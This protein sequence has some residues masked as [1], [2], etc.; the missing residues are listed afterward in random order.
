MVC[1]ELAEGKVFDNVSLRLYMYRYRLDSDIIMSGD[2]EG[3]IYGRQDERDT[4]FCLV[5][6][7]STK[8]FIL[9]TGNLLLYMS[10]LSLS[11]NL[12]DKRLV[13]K[14]LKRLNNAHSGHYKSVE[15][16]SNT[17]HYVLHGKK[18]KNKIKLR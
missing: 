3:K 14:Y 18:R 12:L 17:Y 9:Y 15:L 6:S 2:N 8:R 5:S 11:L 4:K 1:D 7:K 16:A 13:V 10:T